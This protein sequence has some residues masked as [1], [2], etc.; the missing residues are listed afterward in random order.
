MQDARFSR[1]KKEML[2]FASLIFASNLDMQGNL[3][4]EKYYHLFE[5]LPDFL[6]VIAFLDRIQAYLPGWEIPKLT[7]NSYSKDYGFITDFLCE[8]MYEL[9]RIDLLA[10]VRS[11]FAR[12][13]WRD[14]WA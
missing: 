9:R 8:I 2:A 14:F 6:Q 10:S 4:Q 5:P 11:R 1:G 3:L 12:S 7:P 13:T